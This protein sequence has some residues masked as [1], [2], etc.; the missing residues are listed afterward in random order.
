MRTT[1][2]LLQKLQF[3]SAVF[4][5]IVFLSCGGGSSTQNPDPNP[6]PNPGVAD[7][8]ITV[9]PN[10]TF[11]TW[12]AWRFTVRSPKLQT[13]SG[14]LT[15]ANGILNAYMN[16]LVNDLGMNGMRLE[17]HRSQGL[18]AAANDNA[19]PQQL[20]LAAFVPGLESPLPNDPCGSLP[21][22]DV[23]PKLVVPY[24]NLVISRTE[25][26]ELYVSFV[27]G[28]FADQPAWW[29]NNPQEAAEAAQA[30]VTWFRQNFGFA[31]DWFTY[32]E[33]NSGYFGSNQWM[34]NFTVALGA[35]FQSMGVATRIEQPSSVTPGSAVS[36]FDN[37]VGVPGA[38]SRVG[39]LTFHG[40]DYSS[41]RW[42][43]SSDIS[44]RNGVRTR[45]QS[46][47]IATGMT[48]I[49]CKSGWDGDYANGLDLVRDMYL[50][51]TEANISLWEPLGISTVCTAAGCP[52]GAGSGQNLINFEPNL[53]TYYLNPHYWVVRQ[54]VRYIRP[55]DVRLGTTCTGCFDTADR[56]PRLKAVAWR[57]SG[58]RVTVN[59]I[60]DSGGAITVNVT[61]LPSATYDIFKLD[62][63]L[64]V[65]SGGKN[66]CTPQ[67]EVRTVN[68]ATNITIP[69]N[70]V[71]T[72]RQR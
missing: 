41:T 17:Q 67:T 52:V 55:G 72:I 8:T 4:L 69:T 53:S 57:R 45:A 1:V 22:V 59:L 16:D 46:L 24:R 30:Y 28:Q 48:E 64:C 19:D 6:N 62:P 35:K 36:S 14:C 9:N 66:R 5:S 60:N 51:M 32:N 13:P 65:S 63:T 43:S 61:G 68:G 58:G 39:R 2:R 40:Y 47:G 33:P 20:N 27:Y 10:P 21:K 56:G 50:N 3:L 29:Q 18:E 7:A 12:Q 23:I 70:G 26:F 38:S 31:P 11:Q 49:C 15:L 44:A 34:G 42:P 37:L 54:F 25:P 71:W